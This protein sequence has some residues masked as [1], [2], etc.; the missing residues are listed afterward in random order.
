MGWI[1][2]KD[3]RKQAA[4]LAQRLEI[5]RPP[6]AKIEN[7]FLQA[8]AA[9]RAVHG[10]LVQRGGGVDLVGLRPFPRDD[11]DPAVLAPEL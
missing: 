5:H 4:S 8:Q 1:R 10:D 11:L 6:Q 3:R 7:A 9:G 2:M